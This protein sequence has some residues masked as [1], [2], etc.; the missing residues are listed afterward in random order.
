MR[1]IAGTARGRRLV[2]PKGMRVRPTADRV[3]EALFNILASEAGSPDGWRVLDLCAGTGNLGIECLSR[4][5][6]AA[7]FVDSSRESAAVV[8]KNLELTGFA[9][10]SRIV[11]QDALSALKSMEGRERPFDLVLIDPP[12]EREI[13]PPLLERLGASSLLTEDAT[14]VAELSARETLEERYGRLQLT[15]IRTYG[16][17]LLAF[18]AATQTT[19]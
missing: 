13:L 7:V 2:A 3:K 17:T 1:I 10:L 14:V 4:G 11:V 8:R 15:G 5:A 9:A 19:R 6:A 18:F 16:D 12:Y